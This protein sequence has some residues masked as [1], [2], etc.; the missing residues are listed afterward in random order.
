[1]V[2]VKILLKSGSICIQFDSKKAILFSQTKKLT[3]SRYASL[4]NIYR[5]AIGK[6]NV[7][8]LNR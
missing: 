6:N 4:F 7:I 8:G 3:N 5:H 2:L 1:M